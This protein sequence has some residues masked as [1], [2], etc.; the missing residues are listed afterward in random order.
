[1]LG[2]PSI[3]QEVLQGQGKEAVAQLEDLTETKAHHFRKK[4]NNSLSLSLS[5]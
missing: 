3:Q 1:M 4:L 5:L 2:D